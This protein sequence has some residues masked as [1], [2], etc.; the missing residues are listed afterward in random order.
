MQANEIIDQRA[1]YLSLTSTHVNRLNLEGTKPKAF[2]MVSN[3]VL[4]FKDSLELHI[5]HQ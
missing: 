5:S 2:T 3:C 1:T 4:R